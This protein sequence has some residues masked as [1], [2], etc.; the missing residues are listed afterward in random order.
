MGVML[1]MAVLVI[2]VLYLMSNEGRITEHKIRRIRG[3]FAAQ[4]GI[5]HAL[6]Q[7][8]KGETPDDKIYIGANIEGYPPKGYEVTISRTGNQINATVAY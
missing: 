2:T 7:L 8:R 6:E 3:F 5:V 4:A 1:V